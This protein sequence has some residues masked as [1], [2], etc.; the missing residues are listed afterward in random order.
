[1]PDKRASLAVVNQGTT[2]QSRAAELKRRR[3]LAKTGMTAS[4]G[5]LAATGIM[6]GLGNRRSA[7]KTLHLVSGFALIGFSLWHYS[8][9]SQP[10]RSA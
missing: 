10:G 6:E 5:V 3:S 4:L 2:P 1:M 8:L 7:V 9:Y